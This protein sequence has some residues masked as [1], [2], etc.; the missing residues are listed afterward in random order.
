M[1]ELN[2][3][4]GIQIKH[5]LSV[6][7]RVFLNEISA[8]ISELSKM[9][10]PSLCGWSS[11]WPW[12]ELR[13]KKKE[14][15]KERLSNESRESHQGDKTVLDTDAHKNRPL[16]DI[17]IQLKYEIDRY[18]KCLDLLKY[19][20][21]KSWWKNVKPAFKRRLESTIKQNT[22][23]KSDGIHFLFNGTQLQK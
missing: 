12:V 23:S 13:P 2:W 16:H 5:Y 7:V 3:L 1:C 20:Y 9:N 22:I 18:I 14:F 8:W 10:G 17:K 19:Y 6:S 15:V 4:C 11:L 21:L